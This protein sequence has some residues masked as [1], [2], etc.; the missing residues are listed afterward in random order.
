MFAGHVTVSGADREEVNGSYHPIDSKGDVPTFQK[1]SPTIR[2]Y[3]SK[4]KQRWV[5]SRLRIAKGVTVTTIKFYSQ[6][7][8]EASKT[9][10][11]APSEWHTHTVSSNWLSHMGRKVTGSKKKHTRCTLTFSVVPDTRLPSSDSADTTYFVSSPKAGPPVTFEA[12]TDY[13]DHVFPL[14]SNDSITPEMDDDPLDVVELMDDGTQV[15]LR[16][17]NHVE[18]RDP[19]DTIVISRSAANSFVH[20]DISS[21][22]PEQPDSMASSIV[23]TEEIQRRS[24]LEINYDFS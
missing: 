7:K 24:Q 13:P 23:S 11:N 5:I 18:F 10:P 16:D 9:I 8:E 6:P 20:S 17:P 15:A 21:F 1:E 4:S 12:A 3:Y 22:S 19:S 14:D 2:L